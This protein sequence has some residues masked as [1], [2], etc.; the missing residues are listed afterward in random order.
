MC[1]PH[2][3]KK[4]SWNHKLSA[5]RERARRAA[6][7]LTAAEAN[8]IAQEAYIFGLPLVYIAVSFDAE[9]NVAKPAGIRA[10]V[11]QFGHVRE[12]PDAKDNPIVGMNV[13]TLYSIAHL[14]LADEPICCR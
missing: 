9:T 11:N 8:A 7:T 2:S 12:F 6:A 4:L 5:L 14:D 10:P 1:S 3:Q 13:D